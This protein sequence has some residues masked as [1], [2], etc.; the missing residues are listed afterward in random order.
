LA[1]VGVLP[2]G[3][4][5]IGDKRLRMSSGE[6]ERSGSSMRCI[7]VYLALRGHLINDV[8]FECNDNDYF[9]T[10]MQR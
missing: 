10:L 9:A 6:R 7:L 5:M 1:W 2:C 4:G 3:S 8:T